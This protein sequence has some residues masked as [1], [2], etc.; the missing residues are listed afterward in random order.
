MTIADLV[1]VLVIF[2]SVAIAASQG[3]FFEAFSLA[4]TVIGYL[5]ASWEYF[6]VAAWFAAYVK[7]QW[8]ANVAGFLVIFL[9]VLLLA[10]IVARLA[11]W[12]VREVGL[13]WFDRL[14]GAAFGLLRGILLVSVV[15][16]GVV[17][18]AP[19][20]QVLAGSQLAPYFLVVARAAIWLA[21]S[22][23]R[24]QFNQGADMLRNLAPRSSA[25]AK[26]LR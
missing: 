14:L 13:R 21:P 25:P 2:V 15:I 5:L 4:G 10:G 1:I 6:R 22:D 12:A 3:F 26:R 17:T 23:V 18:F 16:L 19:G 8:V 20:S 9:A 24:S 7:T 11:R